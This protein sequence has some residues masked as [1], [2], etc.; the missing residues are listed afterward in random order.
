MT[1]PLRERHHHR[2]SVADRSPSPPTLP[3]ADLGKIQSAHLGSIQPALTDADQRYFSAGQTR[4][5][6]V[7]AQRASTHA[8]FFDHAGSSGHSRSRAH[9]CCLPRSETRRHPNLDLFRGSM[10]GLCAPLSTLRSHPHGYERT[11][12]GRGGSLRLPRDGLA[13]STPC[14]SP[15]ALRS[16]RS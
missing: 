9:P 1:R 6:P 3:S 11:T 13:P 16:S 2:P 15:G 5:L 8:R 4:D 12:R 14:R 7:P 10:A